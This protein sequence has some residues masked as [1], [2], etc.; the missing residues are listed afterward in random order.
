MGLVQYRVTFSQV[1][2]DDTQVL[3]NQGF[4][5]RATQQTRLD[6]NGT[7]HDRT[8]AFK[9]WVNVSAVPYDEERRRII[10]DLTVYIWVRIRGS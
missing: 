5:N 6:E 3:L 8:S 4:Q 2:E 1:I 10:I 9:G 7:D